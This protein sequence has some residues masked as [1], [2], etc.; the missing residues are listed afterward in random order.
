MQISYIDIKRENIKVVPGRQETNL[1][2][3]RL[4]NVRTHVQKVSKTTLNSYGIDQNIVKTA[5]NMKQN[6]KKNKVR[7][8]SIK[9]CKQCLLIRMLNI[10]IFSKH[11]ILIF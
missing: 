3:R 11:F 6:R 2:E 7:K 5:V 1:L 8:V 4:S 10:K 9:F